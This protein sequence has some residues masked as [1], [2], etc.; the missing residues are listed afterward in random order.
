[1]QKQ[2]MALK[3]P[4]AKR[5][6]RQ[7]PAIIC[8]FISLFF[9]GCSMITSSVAE[10]FAASLSHSIQNHEEIKTVEK[11]LPAYLLLTDA[12]IEEDPGNEKLLVAG[13]TLYG[14]Y[15]GLFGTDEEQSKKLTDRAFKYGIHAACLRHRAACDIVTLPFDE[16]SRLTEKLKKKDVPAFYALAASWAS[17]IQARPGDWKAVAHLAKVE[18]LMERIVQLDETY[19]DGSAHVY[20]GIMA[21]LLPASMGGRP[22]DGRRHFERAIEISA[23]RNLMFRVAFARHYARLVFDRDLHN[24]L[25]K[26]VLD[27]DP[28]VPGLVLINN[29]AQKQARELLADADSY[30]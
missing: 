6:T 20:L 26:E 29:L 19:Q 18:N 9:A 21:T 7:F 8:L 2:S 11:A 3:G 4:G 17:W 16:F 13:A 27:A 1:M 28:G 25:L 15:A 14:S 23:D 10:K 22:E 30:F 24:R 5:G 12:M